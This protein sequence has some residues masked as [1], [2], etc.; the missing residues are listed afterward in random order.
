VKPS[1]FQQNNVIGNI[2]PT[3]VQKQAFLLAPPSKPRKRKDPENTFLSFLDQIQGGLYSGSKLVRNS[4]RTNRDIYFVVRT[5]TT[6]VRSNR[7]NYSHRNVALFR[8]KKLGST[9]ANIEYLSG[10]FLE[11][12]GSTDGMIKTI[13]DVQA[14]ARKNNL[15]EGLQPIQTSPGHFHLLWIYNDPLPWNERNESYWISQQTRLIQLFQKDGFNVDVGAS[16]N[17]TQNLRNPSQLQPYNY[18]RRCK[19]EI[20]SSYQKTSLRRIYRSLNATNIPN[21]RPMPAITK[22]RRY[23]R[24]NKTFTMTYREIAENL[25]TSLIT[26]KR[27]VKQEIGNGG[28][29]MTE[30]SGG[31]S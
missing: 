7:R 5:M 19:V 26:A 1:L 27:A 4:P 25:E 14:L 17:P 9:R 3:E 21:P 16:L 28:E 24:A 12:D 11:L 18:K 10:S 20:H 6:E 23:L 30:L 8:T 29:G 13:N 2:T 22:L 31:V 15:L